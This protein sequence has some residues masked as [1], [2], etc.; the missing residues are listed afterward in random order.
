MALANC[1]AGLAR[2]SPAL[3]APLASRAATA[4]LT[5]FALQPK[6]LVLDG[7][8]PHAPQLQPSD[9]LS[10]PPLPSA[11]DAAL[12]RSGR[13]SEQVDEFCS[14]KLQ[15]QNGCFRGIDVVPM[16]IADMD[17]R[18]PQPVID[19]VAE[20]AQRGIYGYTNC[21]N[22]L[23]ELVLGRLSRIYGCREPKAEWLSWLPGLVPGLNHAVRASC[24][25]GHDHRVAVL[26]PAYPPFLK[27]PGLNGATLAPVPL[28]PTSCGMSGVHFEV[29]WSLLETTLSDPAT[30]LMLLCNPHNPTGRCWSREELCRIARLCV[31]NDVTLCS[32]EVWGEVPLDAGSAPFT[33]ALALLPSDGCDETAAD[34]SM[35][36]GLRERLIVL[37]SPSKCFNIA[38]LNIALTAVPGRALRETFHSVGKDAAE[39]TPF[40]YFGAMAAYGSP[41][42]EAWRQRLLAYLRANR[43]CAISA[44]AA[45]PGVRTTR[46]E[47]SYLLWVDAS[48]ALPPGTNAAAFLLEHGVGVSDG[49]DFGAAPGWFRLNLGCKRSTLE[50]GLGRVVSA[51]A[52]WR[53]IVSAAN[54]VVNQSSSEFKLRSPH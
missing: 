38:T 15:G 28:V 6:R 19:A 35:V 53:S 30:R 41:E 46:P 22:Q 21:P 40:G 24:R 1:A 26:T 14:R 29:D 5:R 23:T 50:R 18:S 9:A 52:E 17:F 51:L 11:A 34:E 32:D 37:T 7:A 25:R 44:L 31:A 4:R 45:L 48:D 49:S 12:D 8:R 10:E 42:S 39:V 33:S 43:E 16:W 36:A 13:V 2:R 3:L 27:A 54:G 47:S 20:C